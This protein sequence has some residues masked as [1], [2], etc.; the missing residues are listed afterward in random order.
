MSAIIEKNVT[1][2]ENVQHQAISFLELFRTTK[3]T[4]SAIVC[5]FIGKLEA[6]L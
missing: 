6:I 5:W 3:E 1:I 4:E 2:L